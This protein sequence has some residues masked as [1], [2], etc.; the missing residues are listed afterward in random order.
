VL[1]PAL[2]LAAGYTL[3]KQIF[4]HGYLLLDDRKI[5][6]SLGNVIDPLDLTSV[7][8]VDAVRFWAARAV[9][10]GQDG[11][12]SIESVHERYERELG[13]DLGNLL[14][15]TTAMLARYRG[16]S[17]SR[18]ANR[19]DRDARCGQRNRG[20][21]DSTSSTSRVRSSD[22]GGRPHAQ[23]ARDRR[24]AVELAK[25]EAN[26]AKLDDVLY[27]LVDGLGRR[28]RARGIPPETSP[29]ILEAL[30][31]PD[32]LA[33][34]NVAAGKTVPA[35]G[36]EASAAALPAHRGTG[37]RGVIDTHA[38]LDAC[39]DPPDELCAR[40]REAGVGT[41]LTVGTSVEALAAALALADEHDEVFAIL[42]IHP[43]EAAARR[44]VDGLRDLSH[45]S[46]R[47]P[48]ERPA[49]LLPRLRPHETASA[50]SSR[51]AR[52][53]VASSA[54]RSC[55]QPRGR[56]G[57]ARAARVV[58]RSRRPALLL[59][60]AGA[61]RRRSS[62]V[63]RLVRRQRHVQERVRP[64]RRGTRCRPTASSPRPTARTSR[65][66][67]VAAPERARE[68][69]PHGR[70]ARAVR[71]EEPPSSPRR[72]TRTR[73]R[74]RP[75]VN[76][77]PKKELGQHF[78][79]DENILGVIGRLA[80]LEPDD[81][82]LEIGPGLGRPDAVPR[83]PNARTSMPSSSTAPR[84]DA[85]RGARRARTCTSSSP[86][87]SA[88]TRDARPRR[89]ASSSRTCPYNVATP[90][91]AESLDRPPTVERWTVMVQREVA[92]RL[93]RLARDEGVRRV[94][95]SL[96]LAT[97]RTGFHP[98]SRNVFR[99]R[100]N[101]DSA[102]VAFRRTRCRRTSQRIAG[103]R[104]SLRAPTQDASELARARG[105]RVTR[106]GRRSPRTD[107]TRAERARGGLASDE[108]AALARA[109]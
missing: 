49:R 42:G 76:V 78:L 47:S 89:R 29:R 72:S 95:V 70:G 71:G 20:R 30:G 54:S 38:H 83:R 92:D 18:A 48:W 4:V 107:R 46:A 17:S 3:P 45:T 1:W 2:L 100:P 57:R 102:L 90:L 58:R 88:S 15:R 9:P 12:V 26:A 91:V 77:A 108:F 97:E 10:F 64:A 27:T 68:R 80:E 5:S 86:T 35:D 13:N 43:H 65:P 63:L 109:L 104:R 52:A 39:P 74:L 25:D 55:P 82:V 69:R 50:R 84:A 6:K 73:P 21:A 7:Y 59:V 34:E 94:S 23:Q 101:V 105:R 62:A 28:G 24:E 67:R 75:A 93:L 79:V 36:I 22:L 32:D 11:A 37:H 19:L 44:S 81:V 33:W 51:A 99:P 14:S 8:G 96:Q 60:L 41:I 61:P 31:Q 56:R 40:A 16:R 85:P 53:R 106:A 66:S 98:V 87:R 103:R